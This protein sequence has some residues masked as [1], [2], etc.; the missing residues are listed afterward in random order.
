MRSI[1]LRTRSNTRETYCMSWYAYTWGLPLYRP[2][3]N[4]LFILLFGTTF[5]T[6]HVWKGAMR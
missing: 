3:F 5:T 2:V 1:Q 4:D 6:I